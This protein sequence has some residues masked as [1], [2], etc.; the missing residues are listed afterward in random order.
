MTTRIALSEREAMMSRMNTS[1]EDKRK[2]YTR[3]AAYCLDAAAT[4]KDPNA[5]VMHHDMAHEWLEL[6][7]A[8]LHPLKRWDV[9]K[10]K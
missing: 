10:A 9:I 7:D 1:N 5:R 8:A 2:R 3:Y 6:A 4:T